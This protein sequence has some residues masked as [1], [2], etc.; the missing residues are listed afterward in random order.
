MNEH[1]A[2]KPPPVSDDF[3]VGT[4]FL[5]LRTKKLSDSVEEISYHATSGIHN[6]PPGS[7]LDQ[8]SA[9][10]AGVDAFDATGWQPLP[11]KS[12]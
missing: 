7:M 6:P 11:S 12:I 5:A 1:L 9:K 2:A 8:C 10:L 4:Y 3:I